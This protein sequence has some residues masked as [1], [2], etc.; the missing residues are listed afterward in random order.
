MLWTFGMMTRSCPDP[1]SLQDL[2]DTSIIIDFEI[3]AKLFKLSEPSVQ[4]FM[5]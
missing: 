4:C 1:S 2:T 3:L 5:K